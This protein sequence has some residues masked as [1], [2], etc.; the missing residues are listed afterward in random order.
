MTNVRIIIP[1]F[2]AVTS[3]KVILRNMT[4]VTFAN[5]IADTDLDPFRQGDERKPKITS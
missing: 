1:R 2:P 5:L 4:H 3:T